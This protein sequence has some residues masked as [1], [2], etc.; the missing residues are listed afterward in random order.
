MPS[1]RCLEEVRILYGVLVCAHKWEGFWSYLALT[2]QAQVPK[3]GLY[4]PSG[5][6]IPSLIPF[7]LNLRVVNH[8]DNQIYH[9]SV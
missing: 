6:H 9:A 1:L 5:L 4:H 2:P 3:C 8:V 7:N